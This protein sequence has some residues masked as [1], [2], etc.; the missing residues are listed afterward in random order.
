VQALNAL[1]T[2]ANMPPLPRGKITVQPQTR[3]FSVAD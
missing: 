1:A 3:A 2:E